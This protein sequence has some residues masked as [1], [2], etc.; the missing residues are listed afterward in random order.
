MT[1]AFLK[2]MSG[3]DC[4]AAKAAQSGARIMHAANDGTRSGLLRCIE[5]CL[6]GLEGFEGSTADGMI[7]TA[8]VREG[9]CAQIPWRDATA[10]GEN[11]LLK[12]ALRCGRA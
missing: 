10:F 5:G 7:A 3:A 2:T 12:T 8:C 1:V 9:G 11:R 6:R 4:A